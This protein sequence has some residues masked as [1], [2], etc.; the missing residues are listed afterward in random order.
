MSETGN[1]PVV[2]YKDPKGLIYALKSTAS[3][4]Q[5][6]N[7]DFSRISVEKKYNNAQWR[8]GQVYNIPG[9]SYV[10]KSSKANG[11]S[12]EYSFQNN[13]QQQIVNCSFSRNGN[14]N[15]LTKSELNTFNVF[16]RCVLKNYDTY[17][18]TINEFLNLNEMAKEKSTSDFKS[19][20]K[21]STFGNITFNLQMSEQSGKQSLCLSIDTN[22]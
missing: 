17:S 21:D 11:P 10:L 1:F 2:N 14:E 7:F 8:N 16:L 9:V 13:T 5:Y 22:M 3:K 12:F 20:Q 4:L 18:D 6:K 15:L 19:Y